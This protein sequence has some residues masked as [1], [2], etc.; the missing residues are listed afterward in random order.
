MAV[1]S[2]VFFVLSILICHATTVPVTCGLQR[3]LVE[4][5]HRLLEGMSGLFP[6]ECLELN[7]A[8]AFPFS[9]FQTSE[10]AEESA[11]AERATYE[12]L[13]LVDTVFAMGHMPASWTHLEAFQQVINRQIEESKCIMSKTIHSM[14]DASARD[15]ELKLYFGQIAT[16][17]REQGYSVCAWELARKEI[18]RT[19][20]LI[21]HSSNYLV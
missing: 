4:E 19:L 8:I 2:G 17:L 9:A 14:D 5:S 6:L 7:L 10:S 15:A 1:H 3:R 18:L 13:V 11:A 20:R 12:A 16:V 21:L